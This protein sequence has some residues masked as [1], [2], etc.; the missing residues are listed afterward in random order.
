MKVRLICALLLLVSFNA[1]AATSQ[2]AAAA[3][4][5]ADKLLAFHSDSD[6]RAVVDT[7]VKQLLPLT[8]PTNTSQKLAVFEVMGHVYKGEYRIRLIYY[9]VGRE[10]VLIGQEILELANL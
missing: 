7:N 4:A 9:P 3:L 5:Q 6:D 10:C 2:C 1:T 8:N